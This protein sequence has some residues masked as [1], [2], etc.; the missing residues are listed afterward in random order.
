M[1]IYD[2]VSTSNDCYRWQRPTTLLKKGISLSYTRL[3]FSEIGVI[4][5]KSR[6]VNTL[7]FSIINEPVAV[8]YLTLALS[9][10]ALTQRNN[11][12]IY[13]HQLAN[14]EEL[15]S[16]PVSLSVPTISSFYGL[17]IF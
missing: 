7:S 2:S 5:Y 15:L 3:L 10:D 6:E 13:Y 12:L 16:L 1:K 8:H 14:T 9:H 11:T 4:C 17:Q